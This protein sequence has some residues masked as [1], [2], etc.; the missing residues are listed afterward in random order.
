MVQLAHD[1]VYS[2]LR[3]A[4]GICVDREL[5]GHRDAPYHGGDGHKLGRLALIQQR[6][7]RLKQ[8]K[9]AV[10]VYLE[11]RGEC[12]SRGMTRIVFDATESAP[13][14]SK[15]LIISSGVT[16]RAGA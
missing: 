9:G 13:L 4:V 16:S 7:R 15:C 12:P 6:V 8:D 10:G 1:P 2:G 14:T 11:G 3:R 5:R